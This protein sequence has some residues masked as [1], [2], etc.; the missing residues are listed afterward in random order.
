MP[1]SVIGTT[2]ILIR[3]G[4]RNEPT[5]ANNDPHLSPAGLSRARILVHVLGQANISAI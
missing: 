3:H 4:E 2:V 1:N 5:P